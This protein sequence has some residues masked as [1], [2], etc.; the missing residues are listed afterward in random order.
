MQKRI[1]SMI[2][3]LSIVASLF[4]GLSFSAFAAATDSKGNKVVVNNSGMDTEATRTQWLADNGY[5]LRTSLIR[6]WTS[7]NTKAYYYISSQDENP[8]FAGLNSVTYGK[9]TPTEA[10]GIETLT[11]SAD[12]AG[13]DVKFVSNSDSQ[14]RMFLPMLKVQK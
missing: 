6:D 3:S 10:F 5:D 1:L 13:M 11:K 7:A 4:A 12:S 2:L 9:A 14:K 8:S